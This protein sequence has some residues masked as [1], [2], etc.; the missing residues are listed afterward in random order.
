MKSFP[1][2]KSVLFFLLVNIAYKN[3]CFSNF[4]EVKIHKRQKK[5]SISYKESNYLLSLL[6]KMQGEGYF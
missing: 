4:I 5:Y 3:H 1:C 6:P 2:L